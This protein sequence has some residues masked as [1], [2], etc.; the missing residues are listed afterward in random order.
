MNR[1]NL[2]IMGPPGAGKGTQADLIS[3]RYAVPHI[4]TGNMFR[5]IL[6]DSS[7]EL[8]REL[9]KYVEKGEL[10]PD[11][12]VLKMVRARL[13]NNDSK[14]GFILDGFPR[15]MSQAKSLDLLL[16]EIGR[17]IGLAVYLEAS[18][19]VILERLTGRRVCMHC[20]A[21]YHIKY[22]PPE[23]E[24]VCDRCGGELY[25]RDDDKEATIK[26]RLEIYGNQ[27]EG[28]LLFYK[29]MGCLFKVSGDLSAEE[30]FQAVKNKLEQSNIK[31]V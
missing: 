8:A 21:N 29:N 16:K 17:E 26:R 24:S 11:D 31:T 14:K 25:Q 13:L 3:E 9:R 10:V 23:E 27:I 30:V 22:S 20:E 7:N 4:S 18:L 12:V 15:T 28:I 6:K 19:D 2:L 1:V 5:D